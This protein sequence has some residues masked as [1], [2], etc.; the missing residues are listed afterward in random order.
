MLW[1]TRNEGGPNSGEKK[2]TELFLSK[3]TIYS[4]VLEVPC[5]S[6]FSFLFTYTTEIKRVLLIII[7]VGGD[8]QY[9]ET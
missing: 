9:L 3:V 8:C 4:C 6:L 7:V 5:V 1:D 2:K